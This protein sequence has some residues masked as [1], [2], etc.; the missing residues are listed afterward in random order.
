MTD[1]V[2]YAP[3]GHQWRPQTA[4]SPTSP[5]K[6]GEVNR[7]ARLTRATFHFCEGIYGEKGHLSRGAPTSYLLFAEKVIYGDVNKKK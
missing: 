2:I 7:V 3:H 1:L 5:C 6:R 4:Q